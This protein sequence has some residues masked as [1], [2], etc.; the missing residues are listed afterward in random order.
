MSERSPKERKKMGFW[1][2][3][4]AAAALATAPESPL[5]P[6]EAYAWEEFQEIGEGRI[7]IPVEIGGR[8]FNLIVDTGATRSVVTTAV[9]RSLG[10]GTFVPDGTYT[11][12]GANGR[13]QIPAVRTTLRFQYGGAEPI[14]VENTRVGI[15]D[16]RVFDRADGVLGTSAFL[17]RRLHIN[18]RTNEFHVDEGGSEAGYQ[19][20]EGNMRL[21]VMTIPVEITTFDGR[22]LVVEA[23]IDSGGEGGIW[24]NDAFVEATGFRTEVLPRSQALQGVGARRGEQPHL[25]QIPSMRIGGIEVPRSLESAG[26]G[27]SIRARTGA[28]PFFNQRNERYEVVRDERG[29]A[30][31]IPGLVIDLPTLARLGDGRLIFDYTDLEHP[32][33]LFGGSGAQAAQGSEDTGR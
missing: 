13:E 21:G 16:T 28:F 12:I 9:E 15:M 22:R 33:F 31:S 29:E 10:E 25:V 1:K 30:V 23:M 20:V 4:F 6:Q 2:G 19:V 11:V 3:M 8:T 24:T 18:T 7:K 27:G 14:E 32:K 5:A 26:R 17:G